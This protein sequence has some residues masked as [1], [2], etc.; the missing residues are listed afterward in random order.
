MFCFVV[1]ERTARAND[2]PRLLCVRPTWRRKFPSV[3]TSGFVLT[4]AQQNFL[5]LFDLIRGKQEAGRP[6]AATVK[7]SGAYAYVWPDGENHLE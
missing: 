1:G 7:R 5:H 2:S 3:S 4:R 6:R